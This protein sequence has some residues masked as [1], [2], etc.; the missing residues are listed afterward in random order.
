[1]NNQIFFWSRFTSSKPIELQAKTVTHKIIELFW[2]F[3]WKKHNQSELALLLLEQYR[4]LDWNEFIILDQDF[5]NNSLD[6]YFYGLKTED[7]G[8]LVDSSFSEEFRKIFLC[9]CT[10]TPNGFFREKALI[11]IESFDDETILPFILLRLNDWIDEIQLQ[12][13]RM[14]IRKRIISTNAHAFVKN[15]GLVDKARRTERNSN[16]NLDLCERID[17]LL[18]AHDDINYDLVRHIQINTK[19]R[20]QL[21]LQVIL[22]KNTD[23]ED[24]KRIYRIEHEPFL[25]L[26]ILKKLLEL[27]ESATLDFYVELL[28]IKSS[29]KCRMI[30]FSRV[31]NFDFPNIEPTLFELIYSNL[32]SI[33]EAARD[34]IQAHRKISFSEI[35]KESLRNN[36]CIE[37]SIIG[38]AEVGTA[39]DASELEIFLH[40]DK[41]RLRKLALMAISQLSIDRISSDILTYL[42]D[43]DP[44]VS[45]AARTI[46]EKNK[47]H[48]EPAALEN[49]FQNTKTLSIKMNCL[50]VLITTSKWDSIYYILKYME[51]PGAINEICERQLESWNRSYNRSYTLPTTN[52]IQ[53]ITNLIH[54]LPKAR[55]TDKVKWVSFTLKQFMKKE[56]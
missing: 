18:R 50:R 40:S 47:L 54:T 44:S 53:K 46:Q 12:A 23:K 45:N 9:L 5:R 8:V 42:K 56:S 41:P 38:L 24:L 4:K 13:A 7:P 16:I 48:I 15:Y 10:C 2:L 32:T 29:Q 39:T 21:I 25:K 33:R 52:Q 34:L 1:M 6:Y 37:T 36:F 28:K 3:I 14:L 20:N 51:I 22:A 49:A 26:N 30:I 43:E 17:E 19:S 31:S 11:A 27:T 55:V 35:Y